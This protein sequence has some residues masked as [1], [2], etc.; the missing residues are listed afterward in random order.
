MR[1]SLLRYLTV[2]RF[3]VTRDMSP[4]EQLPRRSLPWSADKRCC[5]CSVEANLFVQV[6][7]VLVSAARLLGKRKLLLQALSQQNSRFKNGVRVQSS[8][9]SCRASCLRVC[10]EACALLEPSPLVRARAL[11]RLC[12]IW[13]STLSTPL[14]GDSKHSQSSAGACLYALH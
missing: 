14:S 2:D 10:I 9:W 13:L 5:L 8:C 1:T 7:R 3:G 6:S 12:S 11:A 4:A